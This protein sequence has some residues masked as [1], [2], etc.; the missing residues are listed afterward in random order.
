MP[1]LLLEIG[2]EEMPASFLAPATAQLRRA[3]E[4]VLKEA[5]LPFGEASTAWTCR[6]LTVHV[7]GLPD[8]QQDRRK[9][10]QGPPADAAF[11]A[12]GKP[13][14]TGAGFA[15]SKGIA[16]DELEVRETPRGRYCFAR[17][18]IPGRRTA[19]LLEEMLPR[20]IA[21]LNFPKSM[22]WE[23]RSFYFA[24]P[25]RYIAALLD[26]EVLNFEL[27]GLKTGRTVRGHR[28]LAPG[29]LPLKSADLGQYQRLL[30]AN[31]VVSNPEERKETIR[32]QA[33]E[34]LAPS[35]SKLSDAELL[36][37][38][39]ALVEY[40]TVIKGGF[41]QDYLDIPEPVLLEALKSEQRYFPVR[42]ADG[43]LLPQFLAVSDRDK[44]SADV[45]RPGNERVLKAK[46]ADARFFWS[47]DTK[48]ALADKFEK[49]SG[50]VFHPKLGSYGDK[51]GRLES[52]VAFLGSSLGLSA[53][54]VSAGRRAARLCKVDLTT[55]TVRE[56]PSLEGIIGRDFA[57][58][59]GEPPEVADAVGEH[60][61][62]RSGEDQV[63]T[64]LLGAIL[65]IA[66][67]LDN[68]AG[69]FMVGLVPT[70][71]QDPYGLRRDALGII[72]V[73]LQKSIDLSLRS[74]CEKA[75]GLQSEA[76]ARRPETLES[77]LGFFRDRLYLLVTSGG[78][79]HDLVR[80]VMSS[81][82]DRLRDFMSRLRALAEVSKTPIWPRLVRAVER[83]YNISRAYQGKPVVDEELFESDTERQLWQLYNSRKAPITNLLDEGRYRDAC[84]D[85]A[86]AFDQ[87][88]HKFFEE[89]FVNVDDRSVRNNRQ[90]MLKAINQLF[91]K[92]IADLSE[93]IIPEE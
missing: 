11:D 93:I 4:K 10:I 91:S 22:R 51:A 5:G 68:L 76:L 79:S 78:Y 58:S 13:T 45:V 80:G 53:E 71:S 67:K 30:E 1:E 7:S 19:E 9:E 44:S 15:R 46:L 52:L 25:I 35:G 48:V 14:K 49:L 31:F 84:S 36:E 39:S 66:D 81:G 16:V 20:I 88:L 74:V 92:R 34:L 29:E 59:D 43:K 61:Q 75:I 86:N 23:S 72:H 33:E 18:V 77:L 26:T 54:M 37:E 12:E 64:S 17:T 82:F 41:S 40:P 56:F 6:R 73:I 27:A 57:L 50:I 63:P 47:E 70:G 65:S 2:T 62:P 90:A 24:R 3:L 69:C 60:Y 28:F 21:A 89:V 83:T 42:D 38:V 87:P 55:L 32:A 8:K 85:Y